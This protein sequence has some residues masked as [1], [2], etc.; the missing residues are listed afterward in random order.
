M[1]T[2]S[3][4]SPGSHFCPRSLALLP[5]AP[6]AAHPA[7]AVCTASTCPLSSRSALARLPGR[8]PAPPPYRSQGAG[9]RGAALSPCHSVRAARQLWK[10]QLGRGPGRPAQARQRPQ[11]VSARRP[12]PAPKP[13]RGAG[14]KAGP[15]TEPTPR[16][17]AQFAGTPPGA[18]RGAGCAEGGVFPER[19]CR[20]N[21]GDPYSWSGESTAARGRE[22]GKRAGRPR[23]GVGR[24]RSAR[25]TG[26]KGG[27]SRGAPAG[28]GAAGRNERAAGPALTWGT[29]R[30]GLEPEL[31]AL[32]PRARSLKA[33]RLEC[34]E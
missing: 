14:R 17:G 19:D 20:E 29:R 8:L 3:L 16:P 27:R 13:P 9:R 21:T 32:P 24:P 34:V 7:P 12:A 25:G 33:G 11:G 26:R 23:G 28:R 30:P 4:P 2:R 1:G 5:L 10:S 22:P 6:L 15:R 18:R 31:R